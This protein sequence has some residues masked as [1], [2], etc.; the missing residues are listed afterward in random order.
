MRA[1]EP[2]GR[3]DTQMSGWESFTDIAT[4]DGGDSLLSVD[5]KQV[6]EDRIDV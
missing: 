4:D 5:E 2:H 6:S 3:L 1:V